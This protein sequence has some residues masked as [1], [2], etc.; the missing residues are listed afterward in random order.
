MPYA[1]KNSAPP[2][3][4]IL[5]VHAD[6]SV[7]G[8]LA[9]LLARRYDVIGCSSGDEFPAALEAYEPDLLLLD[10]APGQDGFSLC[11]RVR[12]SV[13]HRH[14]PVV[15]LTTLREE[16]AIPR[17]LGVNADAFIRKPFH[18]KELLDTIGRLV[19]PARAAS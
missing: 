17:S 19:V 5:A 10:A 13:S 2:R 7:L 12:S 6:P 15:V 14:R 1:M 9:A 11:R 18:L 3:P 16:E 8:A 4:S